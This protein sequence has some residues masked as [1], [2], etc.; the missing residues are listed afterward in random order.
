M[1][2]ALIQIIILVADD[3]LIT[4]APAG[5]RQHLLY[6]AV[7]HSIYPVVDGDDHTGIVGYNFQALAEVRLL[8]GVRVIKD[9]VFGRQSAKPQV[10]ASFNDPEPGSSLTKVAGLIPEV[11]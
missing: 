2:I 11:E 6:F 4:L 7:S 10:R 9:A 3:S 8:P 1:I 5:N